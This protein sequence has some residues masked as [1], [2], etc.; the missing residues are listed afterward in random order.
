MATWW[1]AFLALA[2]LSSAFADIRGIIAAL[3]VKPA[4]ESAAEDCKDEERTRHD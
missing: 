2:A 1:F 3:D 4:L